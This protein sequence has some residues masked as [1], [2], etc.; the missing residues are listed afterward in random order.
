VLKEYEVQLRATDEAIKRG[1]PA[2]S[3]ALI[4]ARIKSEA[5][6]M[7]PPISNLLNGLISRSGAQSA[8]AAQAGVKAA[9]A[10]EVGTF[11]KQAVDG[12]YP[13]V[14]GVPREVPLGDFAK[15][16]APNGVIDGFAKT[17]L[18]GMVDMNG[19]VW[20]PIQIAEGV[21]ALPPAAI[22]NFQRAAAIRDAFF[23]GG[24]AN[25][26]ASLDLLLQRVDDGVSEVQLS[27]DGQVTSMKPGS[28]AG[29]RLS[30]PSMSPTSQIKLVMIVG[31]KPSANPLIFDGPWALFRFVDAGKVEGGTPERQSVSYLE[32][33]KHVFFELRSGSVRNPMRLPELAQFRCPG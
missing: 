27:I 12:R 8:S 31:G 6:R 32:G 1:A 3:D 16:F 9:A 21:D 24:A 2:T 4:V 7:P 23:P 22:A 26:A 18:V 28:N 25:P 15:L 17:K 33:D 29:A 19:P 20:K 14:R 13:F 11:C 5:D 10:G 30:W